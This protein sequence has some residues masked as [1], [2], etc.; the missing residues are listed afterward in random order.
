MQLLSD[1]GNEISLTVSNLSLTWVTSHGAVSNANPI[2]N[3]SNWFSLVRDETSGGVAHV[4][5]P[6]DESK[7]VLAFKKSLSQLI[8]VGEVVER[9]IGEGGVHLVRERGFRG[10]DVFVDKVI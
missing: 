10:R 9:S 2:G 1:S 4:F 6:R 8:S 3:L 7:A 5:Y